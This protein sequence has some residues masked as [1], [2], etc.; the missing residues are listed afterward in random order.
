[1]CRSNC[2][3]AMTCWSLIATCMYT[4]G[5]WVLLLLAYPLMFSSKK[6]LVSCLMWRL[7]NSQNTNTGLLRDLSEIAPGTFQ[8]SIT[9]NVAEIANC[10]GANSLLVRT[11]ALYPDIGRW[12]T[13]CSLPKTKLGESTWQH[14]YEKCE[15]YYQ[16]CHWRREVGR[17]TQFAPNVIKDFILT[18]PGVGHKIFLYQI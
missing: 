6:P 13:L 7:S 5:Q 2:C 12:P 17:E 1:M 15:D 3:K 10:I 14:E 9:V 8:H 4:L 18:H 16:S 11:G